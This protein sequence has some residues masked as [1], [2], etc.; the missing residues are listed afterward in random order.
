MLLLLDNDICEVEVGIVGVGFFLLIG[1]GYSHRE[2]VCGLIVNGELY[3]LQLPRLEVHFFVEIVS[4]I[5][6]LAH[7][8]VHELFCKL[9]PSQLSMRTCLDLLITF[10]IFDV[11]VAPRIVDLYNFFSL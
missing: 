1:L 9:L 6:H 7:S 4:V 2:I 10:C 8:Q 3:E 5:V 11:V